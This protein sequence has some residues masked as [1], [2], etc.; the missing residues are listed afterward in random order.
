V[1]NIDALVW[2]GYLTQISWDISA[3]HTRISFPIAALEPC[4]KADSFEY[5]KAYIWEYFFWPKGGYI[6]SGHFV[7]Y[8]LALVLATMGLGF[9]FVS[10]HMVLELSIIGLGLQ[11]MKA[12]WFVGIISFKCGS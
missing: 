12:P 5:K 3:P 8:F 11:N 2:L 10:I 7:M 6:L 1:P 4:C 9:E